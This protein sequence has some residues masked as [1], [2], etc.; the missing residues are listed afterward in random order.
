[1]ILVCT[2]FSTFTQN[3]LLPV[4]KNGRWGL[5]NE[6]GDFALEV[7]FEYIEF[8]K[9]AQKFT[10]DFRGKK[11]IISADG[12]I[13]ET[14][15]FENIILFDRIWY[16]TYVDGKYNL[17]RGNETV[18]PHQYDSINQVRQNTFLLYT[19]ATAQ[20]YFDRQHKQTEITYS[21]ALTIDT[22]FVLAYRSDSLFDI[23][24]GLTAELYDSN[25]VGIEL[26]HY[27][28]MRY[29]S[30][31]KI[32]I[33]DRK[34]Q[35]KIGPKSNHIA[36][37][38]ATWFYGE[39]EGEQFLFSSND[40]KIYPCPKL[41]QITRIDFPELIYESNGLNGVWNLTQKITILD[42]EYEGILKIDNWFLL[43]NYDRFG[44]A[45][46]SGKIIIP[47]SFESIDQYDNCFVVEQN[48]K[49]GLMNLA[50][51][52][53]TAPKYDRINVFETNIKCY[54]PTE[55]VIFKLDENGAIKDEKR[56]SEYLSVNL[57]KVRMPRRRSVEATFT[58]PNNQ[59]TELSNKLGWYRPLLTR[60][61]DDSLIEYRG[62]W[63]LKD[64]TDS[65]FI[66]PQFAMIT[67]DEPAGLTKVYR[68]RPVVL[69][70]R[71]SEAAFKNG[72]V[73]SVSSN[74]HCV[75][76]VTY[77][78]VDHRAKKMMSSRYFLNVNTS[79][80]I[81]NNLARAYDKS[82]ILIDSRG[83]TKWK[84]LTYYSN[85]E[86][87]ILLICQG[88][89]TITTNDKNQNTISRTKDFFNNLGGDQHVITPN[90]TYMEIEQGNWYYIDNR[91]NQLND[92]AF[93]RANPF[94][95][96]LA[97]V[98][99][100]NKWGVIDTGM[101]VIIPF[102]FNSV[103]RVRIDEKSYFIVDNYVNKNYTYNRHSGQLNNTEFS[104][105]IHYNNGTWFA[106][107]MGGKNWAL[108][109]TNLREL[110]PFEFG[111]VQ[112]FHDSWA[113]VVKNGKKTLID[114]LGQEGLP[115]Y[116]S[117]RIEVL[118]H[119]RYGIVTSKGTTIINSSTDTLLP[120]SL[121]KSVIS[122]NENYI[123]Y[124]DRGKQ[125]Q[126]LNLK[127]DATLPKNYSLEM[128]SLEK[129]YFL[130]RKGSKLNLFDINNQS[131]LQKNVSGIEMMGDEVMIYKAENGMVGFMSFEGDTLCEAKFK[132]LEFIHANLAFA[133]EKRNRGP[134]NFKG[135][136]IFDELVTRVIPIE[137]H[138][139]IGMTTGMGVMN[140]DCE[141]IIPAIYKYITNYNSTFYR[142]EK[143][144]GMCDLYTKE[145]KKINNQSFLDIKAIAANQ[146][147]VRFNQFDYLYNGFLNKSLAFQTIQ[148]ISTSLFLL[149]ENRHI[150]VYNYAGEIVVPTRY[151]KV[152][153]VD[154][155][156]QVGF[157][158]SFGFFKPNGN[159]IFDPY[160]L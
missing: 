47:L 126:L 44:I 28:F 72:L 84:D 122:S 103:N 41:D 7:E 58:G 35:E 117:K 51:T 71:I 87:S 45:N 128:Y 30:E 49:F 52:A 138:Y 90:E 139:L 53:L 34:N 100:N 93:Q 70:G 8:F 39:N 31:G 61:K 133:N 67:I 131:Y 151:H 112:P 56:Y 125:M 91:G 135:E 86:D 141:I 62:N 33:I 75:F 104:N 4:A 19:G 155:H 148:P 111:N 88:G 147:I 116:K 25:C 150:G 158:N 101:N 149:N 20:L 83:F 130:V 9:N 89:K 40:P 66:R 121:C 43:S 74:S 60:M 77:Q 32:Q 12:K 16:S 78:L 119:D 102:E 156:F 80:F 48:G 17:I 15:K 65:I 6:Q 114:S 11:G 95:D 24:R 105:F 144:N 152:E 10:Y 96:Y 153:L 146:L 76:N 14:A 108:V 106:Q 63:G 81:N 68:K 99:R 54:M 160:T 85:Y 127:D 18:I 29:K 123:I 159:A 98:K 57:E 110:T 59:E 107:K 73:Y 145:G 55:L 118:G 109:D 64:S 140:A 50:G 38:Y 36:Y 97:I 69:S 157:F 2:S 120:E 26:Y 129:G 142:A 22:S 42:A 113:A 21:R 27:W 37:Q 13:I 124:E 143:T 92:T 154:D 115:Y 1:M 137:D 136:Y 79:D 82:P 46:E 3:K 23:Y 134:V 94:I 5:V 132:E